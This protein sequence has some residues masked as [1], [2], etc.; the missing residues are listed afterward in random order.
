MNF[1]NLTLSPSNNY[2]LPGT[3]FR[4]NNILYQFIGYNKDD[5]I[6]YQ[7][8]NNIK[9]IFHNNIFIG[10]KSDIIDIIYTPDN[11]SKTKNFFT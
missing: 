8:Y 9:D 5:M 11:N 4:N 7:E 3:I 6:L 10:T 2:I 1:S